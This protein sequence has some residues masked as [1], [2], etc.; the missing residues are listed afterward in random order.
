MTTRFKKN[1]KKR[2]HGR[3]EKHRKHPGGREVRDKAS[4]DNVPLVDVTQ[5]GYFKVLGKGLLPPDQPV[6]VK[7]KL[8][9][10]V[11]EKKIK[12][13]GGAVLLTA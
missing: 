7:A 6:V 8:V 10:K 9:S 5:F 4:K 13:A 1:S 2:G 12:E 3:I 11:A